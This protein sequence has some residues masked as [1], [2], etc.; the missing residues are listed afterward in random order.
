MIYKADAVSLYYEVE[1]VGKPP[2]L[3]LHGTTGRSDSFATFTPLLAAQHQVYLP[4][5]RGHG[6]SGHVAGGYRVLD[7]AADIE[8]FIREVV[9][10]PC[11]VLGHSLGGLVA[12][13]LGSMAPRWIN[14]LVIEDAPLWLRRTTVQAGSQ[15]AYDN[16]K[17]QYELL[18]E[19]QDEATLAEL[20]PQRLPAATA[21]EDPTLAGRLAQLDPDVLRMSFDSS[22]MDGFDIDAAAAKVRCPT[23]L[24]QADPTAGG[25]LTDA[26]AAAVLALLAQ[27]SHQFVAGAGH[28]IHQERPAALFAIIGHWAANLTG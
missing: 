23:L 16:F 28:N 14:G 6:R 8:Q 17:G 4:D 9:G 19:S 20:L 3:L 1:G 5:L 13:A 21:R 22:L 25:S 12:L 26:D 2:F 18:L 10:E 11:F 15:R 7:F 24:V 27:G